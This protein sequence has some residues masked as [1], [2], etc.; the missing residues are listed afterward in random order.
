MRAAV[1]ALALTLLV[2]PDAG[3]VTV[4]GGPHR[5]EV[6]GIQKGGGFS[7]DGT[8]FVAYNRD[9][10]TIRVY[11]SRRRRSFDIASPC[12][13]ASTRGAD[14]HFLVNCPSARDVT[15]E[16]L[17]V[18]QRRVRSLPAGS[19]RG[20]YYEMGR[21]WLRG[22]RDD[23][24]SDG[25]VV[26]LNWRTGKEVEVPLSEDRVAPRDIYS[27]GLEPV[28][29][30]PVGVFLLGR[31]DGRSLFQ[32]LDSSGRSE[33][34]NLWG[35]GRRIRLAKSCIHQCGDTSGLAG[36]RVA[37]S[38]PARGSAWAVR[39][40]SVRSEKRVAWR[41]EDVPDP[42]AVQIMQVGHTREMIVFGALTG[43]RY[44]NYGGQTFE[45]PKSYR[46]YAARW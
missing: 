26:Y 44:A 22:W 17:N 19:A 33:T 2:A 9:D 27:R 23:E 11:D 12:A 15:Q 20:S 6:I 38:R 10:R 34:L 28:R 1:A 13:V 18:R 40:Y 29:G 45:L 30:L 32:Q 31:E 4:S 42:D 24:S 14:G 3:A 37:W 43:T 35:R 5:A 41:V 16:L 36:G 39:G 7:S 8:R 21:H 46:I 25:V